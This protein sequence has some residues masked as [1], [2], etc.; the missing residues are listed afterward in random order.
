MIQTKMV[1][2]I[3]EFMTIRVSGKKEIKIK[4]AEDKKTLEMLT[5]EA[6]SGMAIYRLAR[7]GSGWRVAAMEMFEV[8]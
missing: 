8:R 5:K 2:I 7:V 4:A 6:E 1:S 3:K